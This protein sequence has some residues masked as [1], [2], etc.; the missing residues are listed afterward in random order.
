M[1]PRGGES[2]ARACVSNARDATQAIPYGIARRHHVRR[3]RTLFQRR[4]ILR[5]LLFGGSADNG[6]IGRRMVEHPVERHVHQ[7]PAGAAAMAFSSSTAAK[8][9]GCQ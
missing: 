2:P 8:Y 5:R 1:G 4:Q 7:G 9:A 6:A 3:Q